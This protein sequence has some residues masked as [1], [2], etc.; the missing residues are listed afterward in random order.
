[1]ALPGVRYARW[2]ERSLSRYEES[3]GWLG[4]QGRDP[5]DPP[6]MRDGGFGVLV[7]AGDGGDLMPGLWGGG[8]REPPRLVQGGSVKGAYVAGRFGDW[9]AIRRVQDVLRAQGYRITYDWTVHAERGDNER[10][11]SMTAAALRA[12]AATDLAAAFAADLLVLACVDDMADALGCY[13]ELGAALVA[14]AE[15]HVI[16]PPRP[17][18]FFHLDRVETFSDFAAWAATFD[19]AVAA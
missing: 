3:R 15:V 14:N 11:G 17:S 1:M 6:E 7:A 12:A 5:Q 16:A 19:E 4:S 10:D 2:T 18:I 9:R 8:T 13:V